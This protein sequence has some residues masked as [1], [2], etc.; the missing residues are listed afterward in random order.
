MTPAGTVRSSPPARFRATVERVTEWNPVTRSLFLRPAPAGVLAFTPGQFVSIEIPS[1]DDRPLVRAYS[2]ASSP[3]R[4]DLLEICVDLVPGGGG[5][6]WLFS[7]VPG[8]VIDLKAPFGS[9]TV[10]EPP[11]AEMVFIADAT[12]IAPIRAMVAHV[13]AH[14]GSH[15][16]AVLHGARRES[17]LL[18][19][20]EFE[21][22]MAAHARLRWE[23]VLAPAASGA[24][25][26]PALERLVRE[27]YV[28]AD[29]NRSRHFWICAVGDLVRRLRDALRAAGYE[30]KTVHYEQW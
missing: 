23:P 24:G 28:D 1:A 14:G 6:A 3:D 15:P 13:L 8:A 20:A 11:A 30:R 17:E 5:S 21:T 7:L 25:D 2:I 27:R 16:A 22:W 10:V 4:P 29:T 26:D 19:R 9:F 18:Y 12:A